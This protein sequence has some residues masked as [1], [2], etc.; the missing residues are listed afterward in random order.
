VR[1]RQSLGAVGLV[2][3]IGAALSVVGAQSARQG[4]WPYWG[5]DRAFTRYSA[6]D[7]IT[8]DNVGQLRVAWRQ[9]GVDPSVK[10]AFPELRVSGNFRS[11]PLMIG[12]VLYAPNAIGLVRAM[13]PA[14]GATRWEQK[15]F[16]NTI[17]EVSRPSPRG[18][19]YWKN[20]NDERLILVRGEYL[21]AMD[22]KTGD[23][24]RDFGEQGRVNLH[25]DHQMAGL[26]SWTAGPIIANDVII[27]AGATSGAGD[28]GVKREAAPE[29]V[30]GFDVRTGKLL[31]VFHVVPRPGEFGAD[32]WGD[33]SNAYSGDLASW[34]CLSADEEL[35]Q[36]YIPLSAPTGIVY[37]G[38]RRGDNLFSDSIV[39]LDSKTGKR[40]WHFQLVH[41]DLWDYDAVGPATL[42][43][44]TVNGRRIKALMQ[45]S[46]TAFVYVFDRAT[47][48][49]VWPIEERPVPR[50]T[51]PGEVT[52]RTQPFPTKPPAFDRQGFSES[53]LIDYTPELRARAREKVKGLAMGPLFSPPVVPSPEPG[54]IRGTL[55]MPGG[56]GAGNWHTGAFDP[57]TGYY[58]AVSHT[59]PGISRAFK[60]EGEDATLQFATQAR[61]NQRPGPGQGGGQMG[62][63]WPGPDLSIDGFPIFKG[64][65][66]RITAIDMNRG[67]HVW[68]AANGDGPRHHPLVKD[69]NLPP[70][71]IPGRAAPLL[72]RRLLFIGEGSDSLPGT[73]REGMF[74][75]RFRAFDKMTGKVVW[76]TELPPGSGTTGAPI[77]YMHNGKQYVLVA[78]GGRKH[79]PEWVAYALP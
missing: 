50:S 3:G 8:A 28:G 67:E 45:P 17:E 54:G 70:L 59:L 60:T 78:I 41:H 65:Y 46:K 21:Y 40:V 43:T 29:D 27:V 76:E 49:P 35:G 32:T 18:I 25:W 36:V 71:G 12:G 51:V 13:D 47:G 52:A 15:P 63:P 30:R 77:S 56:W 7:Q 38:H 22:A 26:F 79:D 10:Q 75:N 53:D 39:A 31:W 55:I 58:Y 74:G 16:A 11:T 66:G 34:C 33:G 44:I 37:G 14:T 19:E 9:P 72:T 1:I 73:N 68:T 62:P 4:E 69:L 24:I 42:G 6:L 48:K 2:L 23:Y 64:P 57:E 20:G 5:G 61:S